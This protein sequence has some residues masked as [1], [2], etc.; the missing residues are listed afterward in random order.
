MSMYDENVEMFEE[1]IEVEERPRNQGPDSVDEWIQYVLEEIPSE[2]LI[3]EARIAGG[4]TFMKVLKEEGFSQKD[5]KAIHNAF[6]L[7]F[8][9]E[10]V[11]IPQ[12]M[13]EGCAINYF[14]LVNEIRFEKQLKGEE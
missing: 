7:R 12:Q 11:R 10:K 1:E 13:G 14:N 6:A 3:H 8:M 5:V 2:D 9:R 4:N